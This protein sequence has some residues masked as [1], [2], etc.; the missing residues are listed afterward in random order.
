MICESC[1]SID[2]REWQRKD[3]LRAGQEFSWSWRRG[4]ESAET[5]TVRVECAAVFHIGVVVRLE[6]EHV[7]VCWTQSKEW[8]D[9]L[10]YRA[11]RDDVRPLEGWA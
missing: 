7:V 4:G 1:P 10:E 6:D 5:I 2:V 9:E 8:A 3:L 11:H